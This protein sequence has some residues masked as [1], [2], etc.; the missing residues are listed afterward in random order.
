MKQKKKVKIFGPCGTYETTINTIIHVTKANMGP[1]AG[2]DFG[3]NWIPD[4]VNYQE[5]GM[6]L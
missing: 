4:K 5:E 3:F 6:V 1:A 2:R